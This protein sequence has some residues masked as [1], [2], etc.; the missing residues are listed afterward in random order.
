[1][2]GCDVC[3]PSFRFFRLPFLSVFWPGARGGGFSAVCV[4]CKPPLPL[5]ASGQTHLGAGRHVD[6]HHYVDLSTTNAFAN[7][8]TLYTPTP[9]GFENFE[10]RN[11][12]EQLL[13]NFT[14]ESLQ[15]TFNK[16]VFSN[17][18]RLY[19]EEGIDVVVSSC[20]DNTAC[21]ELLSAKPKGVITR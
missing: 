14:N 3:L 15:D 2:K 17:E 5:L 19:E 6:N 12:F 20:P 16:Q 7:H 4:R 8:T 11:E 21:L 9:A 18:L 10:Y 1:M 13:I